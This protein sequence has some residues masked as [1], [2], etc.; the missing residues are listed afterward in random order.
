MAQ[1]ERPAPYRVQARFEPRV[2]AGGDLGVRDAIVLEYQPDP[3]RGLAGTA[4]QFYFARGAGWCLW[5]RGEDRVAFNRLGGVARLIT[6]W[7]ARDFV[8]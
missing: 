7:C 1:P 4:E 5:T 3:G 8:G 6:P 2:D